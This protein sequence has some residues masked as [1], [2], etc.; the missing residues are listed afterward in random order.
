MRSAFFDRVFDHFVE[1]V[2]IVVG[3]L[4][5]FLRAFGILGIAVFGR[6][7][8]SAFAIG[9]RIIF[10][11]II[12]IEETS[13]GK[14]CK[15]ARIIGK[16]IV[17]AQ[18]LGKHIYYVGLLVKRIGKHDRSGAG[19]ADRIVIDAQFTVAFHCGRIAHSGCVCAVGDQDRYS[20]GPV[21]YGVRNR[22]FITV[23]RY[24]FSA[25]NRSRKVL[26]F[27]RKL[28]LRSDRS[29]IA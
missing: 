10:R 7:N 25:R 1:T 8:F 2:K 22:K 28:I 19:C 5:R 12:R 6:L 26:V 20:V 13:E 23:S 11:F 14:L 21:T 15:V 9:R 27:Y 18:F 24:T 17:V 16:I 29:R 4:F 3:K